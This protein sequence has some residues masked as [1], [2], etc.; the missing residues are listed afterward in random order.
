[1]VPSVS[2]AQYSG[3]PPSAVSGRFAEPEYVLSSQVAL[4]QCFG[5]ASKVTLQAA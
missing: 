1:M 3:P 5:V 2:T 4:G